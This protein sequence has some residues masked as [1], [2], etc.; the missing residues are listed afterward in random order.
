[1]LQEFLQAVHAASTSLIV[2]KGKMFLTMLGI[3]IG[4]SAV[5]VITAVGAGAQNL[6]LSQIQNLGTNLVGVL[7]G[8]SEND[9][10]FSG[11]IGFA[12]TTLTYE[13]AV[14]LRDPRNVPNLVDIVAYSKG[15]GTVTWRSE[16]YETNLSGSTAGYLI[17]EKGEVVDGR[18]FTPTEEKDLS[19]VAVIGSAVQD[20]LFG[21]SEPVG[22]RITIFNQP[23]QVIGVMKERGFVAM[24][25]YDDQVFIPVKTAQRLLGVNHIGLIRASVDLPENIPQA[26][27]D[28]K[29]T[30]RER[31]NIRDTSGDSDDFTV[32]NSAQGI[33]AITSVTDALRYFLAAMA[34][35]SLLVGGIG[36][37]NIML[38]SVTERTREIGLRKAVG[39]SK[40]DILGQ[41]LFEAITITLLGGIIGIFVGIGISYGAAVGIRLF[42]FDWDFVISLRA[43]GVA[44][45][46]SMF[47]GVVF[48]LYPARK[49]SKLD[50]ITA[51][52]YE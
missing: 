2:N 49:A 48:G 12:V 38:I 19:R 5:I 9:N 51:L 1:M 42:G 47:V 17:V 18:F 21:I 28:I 3:I 14:A 37:M 45:V 24:Q 13:D 43:I 52:H 34:A 26:V 11:A 33:S 25:D 22:Q 50:P 40:G 20:E 6:I 30:L 4:V 32:V 35:L 31:H 27:I 7:P 16:S 41:F 44:V 46:I 15:F 23:F 29:A 8:H 36:I 10:P 39:A